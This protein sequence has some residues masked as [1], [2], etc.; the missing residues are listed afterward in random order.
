MQERDPSL[1]LTAQ[2]KEISSYRMSSEKEELSIPRM[3]GY[4]FVMHRP[5]QG[6]TNIFDKTCRSA[7]GM[8]KSLTQQNTLAQW[9]QLIIVEDKGFTELYENQFTL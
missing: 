4:M 9:S 7:S 1:L 2:T 8:S 3:F 5:G 6:P